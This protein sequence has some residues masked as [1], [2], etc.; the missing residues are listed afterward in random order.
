MITAI[1]QIR[2]SR[3]LIPQTAEAV[4][5][6]PGIAEVYSVSG[7]WDLMAI[8]KVKEYDQIAE[9]VTERLVHIPGIVR[10]NTISAFRVYSRTDRE[11]GFTL[12]GA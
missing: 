10:T 3:D 6:V 5:E 9:V 8:V 4:A 7:E 12:G 2:C 1:V 11:A